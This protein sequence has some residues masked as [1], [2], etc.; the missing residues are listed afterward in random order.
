M[1]RRDEYA[2]GRIERASFA[3]GS[4]QWY[5]RDREGTWKPMDEQGGAMLELL[6]GHGVLK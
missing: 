6:R 2:H 1:I 5:G 4:H 3:D